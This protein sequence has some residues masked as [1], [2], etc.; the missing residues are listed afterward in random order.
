MSNVLTK[1]ELRRVR[2]QFRLRC[3][4]VGGAMLALGATLAILALTPAFIFLRMAESALESS[5]VEMS[6]TAK[7][8]QAAHVR[9][10]AIVNSLKPVVGATTTPAGVISRALTHK[11]SGVRI[12]ALN[13]TKGQLVLSGISS[14]RQATG[15]FRD[16]LDVDE[17]FTSVALPVAALVGAQEGR[18]TITL[19]GNF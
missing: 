2:K 3:I 5:Q 4:L 7:S 16:A 6:A 1:E 12:T 9:S 8:D 11:P 15:A 19:R 10:L 17:Y 18:F 14:N 13:Y